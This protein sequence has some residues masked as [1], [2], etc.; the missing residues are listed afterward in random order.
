[1]MGRDRLRLAVLDLV[2]TVRRPDTTEFT[3]EDWAE[4]DAIA[5]QHRLRPLLHIQHRDCLQI[6][7]VIRDN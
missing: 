4:L 1:M 7:A 5:A 2:G 3:Q 6:P